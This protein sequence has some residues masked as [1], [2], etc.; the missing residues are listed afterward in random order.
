MGH[1]NYRDKPETSVMSVGAYVLLILIGA[2]SFLAALAI[3][4]A[5]V[6]VLNENTNLLD[7]AHGK[8]IY[9]IGVVV[10]LVVLAVLAAKLYPDYTRRVEQKF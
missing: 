7:Q 10:A 8:I 6:A 1:L 2:I 9:A 3:N 5:V 4:S